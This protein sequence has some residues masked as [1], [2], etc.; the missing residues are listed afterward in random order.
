MGLELGHGLRIVRSTTR[1][2]CSVWN[3]FLR[4]VTYLVSSALEDDFKSDYASKNDPQ[5]ADDHGWR[6]TRVSFKAIII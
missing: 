5:S 2:S 1:A 6:G 3:V 4:Q